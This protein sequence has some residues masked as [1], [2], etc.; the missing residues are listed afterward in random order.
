LLDA[1]ER[2]RWAALDALETQYREQLAAINLIDPTDLQL[3]IFREPKAVALEEQENWRLI[4]AC[5]PDMMPALHALMEAAP[6]CDILVQ[7]T[8]TEAERFTAYGTPD[9]AYWTQAQL[10]LPD[11][12]IALAETPADEAAY[13]E[14]FLARTGIVNPH[15]ICLGVLNR[16]IMPTLTGSFATHGIHIFEPSPLPLSR[17]PATRILRDLFKLAATERIELVLPLL[18]IPEAVAL[19]G[20]DYV[21]L[22]KAFVELIDKHRPATL[23]EAHLFLKE[24]ALEKLFLN[25]IEQWLAALRQNPSLGAK[26]VLTDL[27]GAQIIDPVKDATR[28]ATFEALQQLFTEMNAIRVPEVTPSEA[29]LMT[30]LSQTSIHPIR[31]TSETSYEG[32]FEILW[33]NAEQFVVAG[34]NEGIFPDTTFEDAFLPNAFRKTLGLRSDV[35]RIARDAYILETL[36]GRCAP[37]NLCFTASRLNAN[38]DW[39][40]PS[41]LFF[42]C[43]EAV[44][45]E[46]AKQFFLKPAV[47]TLVTGDLSALTFAS[48][49]A[50]WLKA[51]PHAPTRLSPSA[52]ARFLTAPILYWMEKV[53]HAHE[54]APLENGI[55]QNTFGTLIHTAMEALALTGNEQDPDVLEK[56][57]KTAFDQTFYNDYG[58]NPDVEL[59]ALRHAAHKRL[60]QA[61]LVESKL[62][63]DGWETRYREADTRKGAWEVPV[64]IGERWITL[65][66]QIDRIDYNAAT[67]TWRVIDYK[68]G[69][70]DSPEKAHYRKPKNGEVIWSSFQLPIYRLL[71][72]HALKLSP[73]DTVEM[74]Y[75]T[76]PG[77]GESSLM[78]MKDPYS[79]EATF[80]DLKKVLHKILTL[81]EETLLENFDEVRNPLLK[82]LLSSYVKSHDTHD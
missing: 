23:R 32:R 27:F 29:L 48:S 38:G 56:V 79:E 62:R 73:E 12:S 57:L 52:I 34:L 63:K 54:T 24:D 82:H 58:G 68:T 43:A 14:H 18:A 19:V 75:F 20:S 6:Q 40:K 21:T 26:T 74:A 2:G 44:Q 49:P 46:R 5:V 33:S 80:E 64:R 3:A 25:R 50:E 53:L 51:H 66:G 7:A 31:G 65:Y 55:Q 70:I 39:I 17:Q 8:A 1:R 45:T 11:T 30:R 13:I 42:R 22:R 59:L 10:S 16:E 69:K 61:A 37:E 28:F 71:L 36:C 81:S 35:N 9:P 41:R 77:S 76:L 72:R 78:V 67:K 15:K 47:Q 4:V 60:K